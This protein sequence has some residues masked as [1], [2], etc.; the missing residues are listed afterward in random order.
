[1]GF[2]LNVSIRVLAYLML[3]LLLTL[4]GLTMTQ[5]EKLRKLLDAAEAVGQSVSVYFGSHEEFIPCVLETL[6]CKVSNNCLHIWN[7]KTQKWERF[8]INNITNIK[9]V[10]V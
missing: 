2:T 3:V 1:M 6:A 8:N 4:G 9:M 7:F 10:L 5:E